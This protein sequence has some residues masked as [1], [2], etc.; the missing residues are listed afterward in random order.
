[1]KLFFKDLDLWELIQ[2]NHQKIIRWGTFLEN[3]SNLRHQNNLQHIVSITH[4]STWICFELEE[5]IFFDSGLILSAINI[6]EHGEALLKRDI[7]YD[8]KN[9]NPLDDVFEYEKVNEIFYNIFGNNQILYKKMQKSFLL[10]FVTQENKWK[11]FSHEAQKI[12]F[13]LK[14]KKYIE[15]KIFNA[16]ERYEYIYYCLEKNSTNNKKLLLNVLGNQVKY[17]DKYASG[18]IPG[19]DNIWTKEMSKEA[20][21]ILSI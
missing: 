6:H 10:Q 20:K 18:D 8:E 4:V 16:I 3:D 14:E 21:I 17:L 11:N 2:I 1:M 12:L 13:N 9:K 7:I 5:Y 15:G 19:F